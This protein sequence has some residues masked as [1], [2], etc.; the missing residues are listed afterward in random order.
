MKRRPLSLRPL[1]DSVRDISDFVPSNVMMSN[2]SARGTHGLDGLD[3]EKLAALIDERL[4]ESDRAA[5]LSQIAS[6]DEALSL[7]ADAA[8]A[9]GEVEGAR[10]HQ[11]GPAARPPMRLRAWYRRSS[12]WVALA[13]GVIGVGLFQW[14]RKDGGGIGSDDPGRFAQSLQF[15]Q[16]MELD[17]ARSHPWSQVRGTQQIATMVAAVRVGAYVTDVQL[18]LNEPTSGSDSAT[19]RLVAELTRLLDQTPGGGLGAQAYRALVT[20]SI[21][22]KPG[23]DATA[24]AAASSIDP[25]FVDLG[26]W[27]EAALIATH[28]HDAGFFQRAAG[29]QLLQRLLDGGRLTDATRPFVGRVTA[30]L[31]SQTATIDWT[32]LQ[33]NV[34]QMVRAIAD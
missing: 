8:A 3:E 6:S 11:P 12:V 28:A 31:A 5:L 10:E 30:D 21:R 1:N 9:L 32:Q 26:A 18:A 25:D 29:R 19:T 7:L 24:R 14:A 34:E 23:E 17:V 33:S 16:G 22:H 2:E 27:A 20:D 15:R 13:A 4:T